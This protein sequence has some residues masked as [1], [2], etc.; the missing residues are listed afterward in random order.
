MADHYAT[1]KDAG[2]RIGMVLS[3]TTRPTIAMADM[4]LQQCDGVI[5]S[6]MMVTENV[7]DD[8][9]YLRVV[10]CNVFFKMVNNI[11]ALSE[12]ERYDYMQVLLDEEDKK[13]IRMAYQ[14]WASKTWDMGS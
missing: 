7:D 5:N 1:I 9:G 4:L 8:Y 10:E 6:A 2:A 12:P 14:K 13:L 3:S 11:L